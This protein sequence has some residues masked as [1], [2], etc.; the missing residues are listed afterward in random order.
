MSTAHLL[1]VADTA[2]KLTEDELARA[3]ALAEASA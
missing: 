2:D 3:Y 1:T